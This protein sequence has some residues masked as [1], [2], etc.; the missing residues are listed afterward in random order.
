MGKLPRPDLPGRAFHLTARL[1]DRAHRFTGPLR[2]RVVQLLA[3][4]LERTDTSLLAFAIM[5][6]HLHLVVVQ[7]EL[8]LSRLMQPFLRSVALTVQARYGLQGHVFEGPYRDRVCR[9]EPHLRNSICYTHANPLRAGLCENLGAYRWTSHD[10]YVRGFLSPHLRTPGLPLDVERGLAAV[11][12]GAMTRGEAR[13]AYLDVMGRFGAER[14]TGAGAASTDAQFPPSE[15]RSPVQGGRRPALD[16]LAESVLSP[17]G[18]T[19]D[20]IRFRWGPRGL[21]L[22]GRKALLRA[23]VKRGFTGVQLAAFLGISEAT[24][25]R[26]LRQP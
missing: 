11:A 19:P 8:H 1:Q 3:A 23:A 22:E 6:N 9:D 21:R 7:G 4:A 24:V 25:S 26:A 2:D 12:P 17:R 16:D 14:E 18:L 15:E 20:H 10:A 5:T 13:Q